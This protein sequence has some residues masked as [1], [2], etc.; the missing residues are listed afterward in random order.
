M[1][2]ML[3]GTPRAVDATLAVPGQHDGAPPPPGAAP[4]RSLHSGGPARSRIISAQPASCPAPHCEPEPVPWRWPGRV[5]PLLRSPTCRPSPSPVWRCC[6]RCRC[7]Q[8][9]PAA[10]SPPMTERCGA[11]LG[12]TTRSWKVSGR[13]AVHRSTHLVRRCEQ[14]SEQSGGTSRETPVGATSACRPVHPPPELFCSLACRPHQLCGG[15]R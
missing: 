10:P 2:F 7:L 4:P 11:C 13:L 8:A 12:R 6:C 9:L 1:V 3:N 5:P 14:L 15:A